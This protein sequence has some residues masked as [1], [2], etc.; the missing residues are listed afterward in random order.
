M[1]ILPLIHR[2]MDASTTSSQPELVA[3]EKETSSTTPA[4]RPGVSSISPLR[5]F[6]GMLVTRSLRV[7]G[8]RR[9]RRP[10]SDRAFCISPME[11]GPSPSS[12]KEE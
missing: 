6:S 3:L 4:A 8:S 7:P 2:G 1:T 9:K 10:M 11:K 12:V 5:A